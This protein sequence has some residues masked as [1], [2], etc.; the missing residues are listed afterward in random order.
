MRRPCYFSAS[1]AVDIPPKKP[2]SLLPVFKYTP[3]SKP[4]YSEH[5]YSQGCTSIT[6]GP[7][8]L[9]VVWTNPKEKP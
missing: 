9:A 5:F 2:K 8:R 4:W 1:F 3:P 6:W 7:I